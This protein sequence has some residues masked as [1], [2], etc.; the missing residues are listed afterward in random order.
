IWIKSDNGPKNIQMHLLCRIGASRIRNRKWARVVLRRFMLEGG[1]RWKWSL[2]ED[3][4]LST[5][6]RIRTL[7]GLQVRRSWIGSF[8]ESLLY[9]SS[10]GSRCFHRFTPFGEYDFDDGGD[11]FD[12]DEDGGGGEDDDDDDEYDFDDGG[13]DFDDDEDGGGGED[14]DDDDGNNNNNSKYYALK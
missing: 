1:D 6:N 8:E 13:D 11:D 4:M 12:D 9:G 2:F 5:P 14:D 10:L 3:D 7:S